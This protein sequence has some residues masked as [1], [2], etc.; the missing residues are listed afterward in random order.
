MRI[1]IISDVHCNLEGLRLALDHLRSVDEVICAGD[2]IYQY[3]FS[4]EVVALLRDIGARVILGNHEATF[5]GPGGVRA[6]RSPAV[7]QELVAW[8]A[9]QPERIETM[10]GGKRLLVVHG[11]PWDPY[12][13]YVYPHSPRLPQFREIDAAYIVLGHTHHQMAVRVDGRLV[14]NPGSAGDPRDDRNGRRLSCAILDTAA[15]QVDFIDFP[16]PQRA[17]SS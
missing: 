11:S 2:S 17:I 6:R 13:E 9:E 7:D 14:L 8:L 5:L 15:D 3:R 12:G 4:N 1:G 16:D 10:V